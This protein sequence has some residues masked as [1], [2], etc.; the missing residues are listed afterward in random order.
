MPFRPIVPVSIIL[1]V[2][3]T[4]SIAQ[5]GPGHSFGRYAGIHWGDGYHSRSA[6]PPKRH[7]A[8]YGQATEAAAPWWTVPASELEKLPPPR[9]D[10]VMTPAS[11]PAGPSLFRQPGEGSSTI[12]PPAP[13]ILR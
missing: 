11:R 8:W 6:C 4:G 2:V 13:S 1:A 5:A 10:G 3:S 7:A 12:G 9:Q